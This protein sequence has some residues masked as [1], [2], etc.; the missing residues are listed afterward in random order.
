MLLRAQNPDS[1]Q[2]MTDE[3]LRDE[4]MTMLLAGH[5]TTAN[6][7]TWIWHLLD[8]HPEVLARLTAE[9]D[10]VLAGRVPTVEDLPALPYTKMVIQEALRVYP[11][12]WRMGRTPLADDA[13]G[14]Y[15]IPAGAVLIICQYILHRDPR[16]WDNPQAFDPERFSAERSAN[17]PRFAYL[18]FGAGPRACIGSALAMLEMQLV[19]PMVV[20]RF[21]LRLAPG[22]RVA[23][24]PLITL[25]PRGGMPMLPEPRT[26][27]GPTLG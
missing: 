26:H 22:H 10:G 2:G 16:Y 6:A 9:V 12:V 24:A 1:G 4:V 20:E 15:R 3:Q 11:P 17:R 23:M 8:R 5:E 13:I 21:R 25:R 19:V 18:P 7:L 27:H 14:G